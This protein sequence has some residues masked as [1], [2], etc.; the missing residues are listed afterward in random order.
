MERVLVENVIAHSQC[1]RY[2]SRQQVEPWLSD[3]DG[4]AIASVLEAAEV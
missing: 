3:D 2:V 1:T 4:D